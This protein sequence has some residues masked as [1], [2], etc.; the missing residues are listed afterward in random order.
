MKA[1]EDGQDLG[2]QEFT[3]Q[4]F[5][6]IKFALSGHWL[7]APGQSHFILYCMP[8]DGEKAQSSILVSSHMPGY[9]CIPRFHAK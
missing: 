7:L 8:G 6:P 2:S 4:H 1:G 3:T 9:P 5:S